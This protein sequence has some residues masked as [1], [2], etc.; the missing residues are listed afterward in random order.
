MQQ[1]VRLSDETF[2]RELRHEFAAVKGMLSTI[3]SR[4]VSTDQRDMLLTDVAVQRTEKALMLLDNRL[5]L[6]TNMDPREVCR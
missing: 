1:E 2:L 5:D 6:V 4:F 3:R